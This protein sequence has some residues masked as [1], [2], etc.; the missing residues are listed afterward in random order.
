MDKALK[1]SIV[2]LV[3][4]SL[5]GIYDW[6]SW[7]TWK[8]VGLISEIEPRAIGPFPFIALGMLLVTTALY[9]LKHMR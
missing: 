9:L 2:L 8:P 5:F 1:V 3:I 4:F 7:L 6:Y